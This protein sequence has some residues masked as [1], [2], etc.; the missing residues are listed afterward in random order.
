MKL[1][2]SHGP[3][4][5]TKRS[6]LFSILNRSEQQRM[7]EETKLKDIMKV[8]FQLKSELQNK[9]Q[10]NFQLK[11]R[12]IE[13]ESNLKMLREDKLLEQQTHQAKLNQLTDNFT[14]QLHNASVMS[15]AQ[16]MVKEIEFK[17]I[18]SK[19]RK[20]NAEAQR[21]SNAKN[22]QLQQQLNTTKQQ[23]DK[24]A[25]QMKTNEQNQIKMNQDDF[26]DDDISID[27]KNTTNNNMI[28]KKLELQTKMIFEALQKM[29]VPTY[30]TSRKKLI[31]GRHGGTSLLLHGFMI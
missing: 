13:L 17:E 16:L 19:E 15:K 2:L 23:F 10:E 20:Q 7:N 21:E 22:E 29:N 12:Q 27:T 8:N 14:K 30:C 6:R 28:N 11:S 1:F 4:K 26:K 5:L 3:E 18:L 9:N 25:N 31:I 24:L